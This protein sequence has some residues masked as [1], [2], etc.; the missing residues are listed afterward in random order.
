MDID[1]TAA[2]GSG[3]KCLACNL[4]KHL[5]YKKK[6]MKHKHPQKR[7]YDHFCE[8]VGGGGLG[9]NK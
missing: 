2:Y 7:F 4:K 1:Q 6:E 8:G 3:S 9:G 5:L